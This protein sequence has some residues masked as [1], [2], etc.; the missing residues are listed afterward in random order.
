MKRVLTV[1]GCAGLLFGTGV[2]TA[3]AAPAPNGH[4][5]AGFAVSLGA[6]PAFGPFVSVAAHAQLVDNAGFANCDQD[7]RKNP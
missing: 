6:G 4:N 5:C 3:S 2:S 1:V 7:N